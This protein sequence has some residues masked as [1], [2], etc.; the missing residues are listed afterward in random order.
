MKNVNGR[1]LFTGD[2]HIYGE[3]GTFIKN[4][5][6]HNV[7]CEKITEK[8]S[9]TDLN[10]FNL[11]DPITNNKRGI[12][13]YGV[14]GVGSEDSLI[15]MKN[16]GFNLATFA[17]NHTYDMGNKG[18]QDTIDACKKYEIDIV[19][20]GLTKKDAQKIYYKKIDNYNIAILNFSRIEFNEVNDYH[21]GANPLDVVDNV[22]DIKEAMKNAD[23]V[24]VV[25]HEGVDVFHL[26]YPKLV[27]Q[28][29]FYADMGAD[30]IILHHSRIISGYEVYN[31]TPIF[32]GLG[33]L[34]HLTK[35]KDEHIGL[36][37][38]FTIGDKKQL[39]FELLPIELDPGKVQVSLCEGEK[40]QSIITKIDQLSDTIKSENKLR[41]EWENYVSQK[42]ALY[43]SILSGY[44]I[45]FYRIA[46][47]TGLLRL[48]EK[49]LLTNKKKYL[50]VWN[51]FRCQAHREAVNKN[52]SDIYNQI[53][54]K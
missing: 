39:D 18:I 10:V 54:R 26:P 14:H 44:P 21:G 36:M 19:G 34:L 27:K 6:N 38:K 8:L 15:P 31:N 2:Y 41:F 1:L 3:Y 42:K 4:K 35:N 53:S 43:L 28:M 12:I 17:T 23:I 49:F 45:V 7:F 47:N 11:E 51:I 25:V 13:K 20:A 30:A 46:K 22:K 33:N 40:K 52:L 5:I 48:Y 24:F 16:V 29:R 32:Y 50:A 9:K 37:V